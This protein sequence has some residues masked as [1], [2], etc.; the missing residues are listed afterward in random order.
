MNTRNDR[1]AI[2]HRA[3]AETLTQDL[4]ID[5][6]IAYEMIHD[7]GVDAFL[8]VVTQ[9]QENMAANLNM[10]SQSSA[11]DGREQL[12]ALQ[13]IRN[14]SSQLGLIGVAIQCRQVL[15]CGC[16]NVDLDEKQV[17][18]RRFETVIDQSVKS[19]REISIQM[20]S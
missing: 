14:C 13:F 6:S 2:E 15:D 10:L 12:W 9:Y 11:D 20:H 17:L 19:L 4:Q 8:Q 1:A 5:R 3:T 18:R 16:N 7:F